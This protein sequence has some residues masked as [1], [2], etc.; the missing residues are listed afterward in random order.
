[1][2][3]DTVTHRP[4]DDDE[5]GPTTLPTSLPMPM[6]VQLA[7]WIVAGM[8]TYGV[9]SA[10]VAVLES[11]SYQLERRLERIEKNGDDT[12]ALLRQLALAIQQRER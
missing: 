11:S 5:M 6:A 9:V 7:I 1:M 10:R 4:R 12:Q 8:A 3:S 2:E